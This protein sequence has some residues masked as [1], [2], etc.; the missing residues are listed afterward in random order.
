M[1]LAVDRKTT[2]ATTFLIVKRFMKAEDTREALRRRRQI[3]PSN[4]GL[5]ELNH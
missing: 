1:M 5:Y 4:G 2:I 3:T